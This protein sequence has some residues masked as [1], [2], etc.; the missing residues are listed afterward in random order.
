MAIFFF[1]LDEKYSFWFNL[2]KKFNIF[3]ADIWYLDFLEYVKPNGDVHFFCF[4]P[5][6][7]CFFQKNPLDILSY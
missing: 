3:K 2:V 6:F 7:K 4:R 5:F 1:F